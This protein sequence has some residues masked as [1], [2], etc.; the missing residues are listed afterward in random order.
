MAG[1]TWGR[2][3]S[4]PS[5]SPCC[6]CSAGLAKARAARARQA[7]TPHAVRRRGAHRFSAK[8]R[9]AKTGVSPAMHP[10]RHKTRSTLPRTSGRTI[11]WPAAIHS[12]VA[13]GDDTPATSRGPTRSAD[14]DP[15]PPSTRGKTHAD[16]QGATRSAHLGTGRSPV[17]I[18]HAD[19]AIPDRNG[20]GSTR[21]CL[22][23][24][25]LPRFPRLCSM[26]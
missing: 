11:P 16:V 22:T 25:R 5:V 17:V 24:G 26:L 8:S 1:L 23:G 4:G 6:R 3:C 2:T 13:D 7:G 21:R 14:R 9:I 10:C 12:R 19:D 15:P 20:H 18:A